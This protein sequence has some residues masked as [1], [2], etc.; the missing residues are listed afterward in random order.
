MVTNIGP[1]RI[2]QKLGVG[3]MAEVFKAVK[4][5]PL[6]FEKPIALKR[7][8]P[9]FSDQ[10]RF[11]SLFK[12]E[13]K[14]HAHLIHPNIVQLLD[15]G[16]DKEQ[17]Y[18]VLELIEGFDLKKILFET[19][20]K[21]HPLEPD[22]CAYIAGEILKGLVYAHT[23]TD[24]S[25]APLHIIH[26]DLSPQNVLI[27]I[28]GEVKLSDFGIAKSMT[29]LDHT[30]TRELK[31]KVPYFSPEQLSGKPLTEASDLFSFGTLLFELLTGKLPFPSQNEFEVMKIIEA[32]Q[33]SLD[34][35]PLAFHPILKKCF[36][37]DLSQRYAHATD[38]LA[39][40]SL[41]HPNPHAGKTKL[42][43]LLTGFSDVASLN[44]KQTQLWTKPNPK[45]QIKIL[46][47]T[48]LLLGLSGA[49]IYKTKTPPA[50]TPPLTPAPISE[51]PLPQATVKP[52][53]Q[54]PLATLDIRGPKSALVFLNGKKL[55]P[56]PLKSLKLKPGKYSL[57]VQPTSGS[58]K[59]FTFSL[60]PKERKTV[61]W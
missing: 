18:L 38:I 39:D 54:L 43:T 41:L 44:E 52:Q 7:I 11:I 3:G 15:Y 37:K 2:L 50:A 36:Q 14:L 4:K 22:I 57:L 10:A 53:K 27:S 12:S 23:K 17:Y 55:G 40:L 59:I 34:P 29:A 16:K 5:T 6:G 1:Y 56:L 13:T 46:A 32:G 31:G 45:S 48:L 33:I 20:K 25:G 19:Q 8:L 47:P 9:P 51:T 28:S 35:A 21:F 49:L 58:S 60:K 61:A 24:E 26:R 30:Q 42:Q